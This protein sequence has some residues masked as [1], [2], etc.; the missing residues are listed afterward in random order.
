MSNEFQ[1]YFFNTS[2]LFFERVF[3]MLVALFVGAYVARYLGPAQYG[4]LCYSISFVT[5]FSAFATLGLDGIVIRELVK[6]EDQRDTLLGTTFWLK[7]FGAFLVI[8]I[9]FIAIKFTSNSH[10]TNLIVF[11]IAFGMLFQS[12]DVVDYYFQAKVQ[13]K[14]VVQTRFWSMIGVSVAKIILIYVN[15]PLLW[16]VFTVLAENIM[17]AVGLFFYYIRQKLSIFRWKFSK[18]VALSLLK[19]SWPLI[20]SGIV[21]SIYMRIDQVM[22]KGMLDSQAVGNYAVAVGLSETWYFIPTVIASSLFPAIVEAKNISDS[23]YYER[24]QKLYDFMVLCAVG[25]AIPTTFLSNW[26]ITLLYGNEYNLAGPVLSIYIWAGVFVFLGVAM[27][28]WT[29]TE[30]LQMYLFLYTFMGSLANVLLNLLL[31]P[32]YGII[33]SAYATLIAQFLTV[34]AIPVLFNKTRLTAYMMINSIN[35]V[36]SMKRILSSIRE[37]N[38]KAEN[39]IR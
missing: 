32:K 19:N 38:L 13:S 9:L 7:V 20:F 17:V 11:I 28:K 25:I 16:F 21:I 22:I 18:S 39:K 36:S 29:L 34:I 37:L 30:N 26:V 10:E 2:W 3:R 23:L 1:K 31:I 12:T 35:L 4:L 27:S 14:F 24:F 33:G 8:I 5:L 6:N 15:A